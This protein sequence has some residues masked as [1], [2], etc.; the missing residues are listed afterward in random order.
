MS[1]SLTAYKVSAMTVKIQVEEIIEHEDGSATVMIN[2]DAES[3]QMLIE[4]GFK[5]LLKE[6][7]NEEPKE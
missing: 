1:G 2:C 3:L 7:M 5:S 4:R 6:A